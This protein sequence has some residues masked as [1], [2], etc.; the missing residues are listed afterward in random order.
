VVALAPEGILV[1]AGEGCLLLARV[2]PEGKRPMA[3]A[4]FARGARLD[5]GARLGPP[6]R[7]APGGPPALS[8]ERRQR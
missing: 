5:P 3:A 8:H 1:R 4:D 7:G 6:D 2:Q